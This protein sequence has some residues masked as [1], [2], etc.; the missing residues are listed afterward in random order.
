MKQNKKSENKNTFER[1]QRNKK[2]KYKKNTKSSFNKL[3]IYAGKNSKLVNEIIV[4]SDSKE[5]IN[6]SKIMNLFTIC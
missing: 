5:I 4:S 3:L 6:V 1:F 2:K